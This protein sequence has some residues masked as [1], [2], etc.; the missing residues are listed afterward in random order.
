MTATSVWVPEDIAGEQLAIRPSTLRCMRRER[1]LDAGTH[2]VYA[3]GSVGGP[4]IYC[5]PA[6]REMQRQRT[7]EAVRKED[8]RREAELKLRQQ[9]IESYDVVDGVTPAEGKA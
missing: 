3:T 4:V 9:A 8:E 7:I 1:R 2:W 6:I 5:I